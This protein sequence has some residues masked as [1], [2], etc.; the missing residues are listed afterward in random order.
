MTQGSR[1][2]RGECWGCSA[3]RVAHVTV[4]VTSLGRDAPA[5]GACSA[6][7]RRPCRT[8]R[9]PA[10]SHTWEGVG[11]G[12]RAGKAV[13][14]QGALPACRARCC[15]VTGLVAPAI[16]QVGKRQGPFSEVTQLHMAPRSCFPAV[17]KRHL[18]LRQAIWAR[19]AG[20]P[21]V[22]TLLRW[23]SQGQSRK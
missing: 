10:E 21:W 9:L 1:P 8:Q 7:E 11:G 3:G 22:W 18:K 19:S 6:P 12:T 5:L 20:E 2:G 23:G 14:S 16:P 13:T 15:T 4:P 17:R